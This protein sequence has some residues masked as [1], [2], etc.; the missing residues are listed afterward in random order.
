MRNCVESG[1]MRAASRFIPIAA[2]LALAIAAVAGMMGCGGG[3]GIPVI[4]PPALSIVSP[5]DGA[6][7][8]TG[9]TLKVTV[10]ATGTA[11][12][13]R[14]VVLIGSEGLGASPIK[15]R[16]PYDFSL[17][18]P[19]NLAPGAYRL[20]ALGFGASSK[21]LASASIGLQV[22]SPSAL[23]ILLPPRAGEVDFAAIGEQLPL[24]VSG[25]DSS[26]RLLDLTHSSRLQYQAE[27]QTIAVVDHNGM[28]T[29]VAPGS[30]A[31]DLRL[32]GA[33]AGSIP[34]RVIA[35]ALIPSAARI[36]FGNQPVGSTSGA[37]RVS[38]T[39]DAA[40]AVRILAVNSPVNFPETHSCISSSPLAPGAS[41]AIDVRFK[42][43]KPGAVRGI[44]SIADSAVIARTQVFLTGTGK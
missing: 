22:E 6:K 29:A 44:L 37:M 42:P 13:S 24:R 32:D 35:P 33:A 18:I 12:L 28:V 39:N 7:V 21:P 3:S 38:L 25:T 41:C 5:A 4:G 20:T 19:A 23:L 2:I 10:Q 34:I 8:D 36:D 9:Q 27:D 40:F 30:S 26:G 14:G 11:A 16:P 17:A 31:I 15:Q 43:A 1:R